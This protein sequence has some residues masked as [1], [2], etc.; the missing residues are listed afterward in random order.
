MN[1]RNLQDR[2]HLG[3]GLAA[4]HIGRPTDAFRP[5]GALHPLATRNRYLRLPATF[6]PS[7]GKFTRT[8]E[9]GNVLWFGVFDASY[10]RTGDY[11]VTE[12]ATFFVAS[13]APLLPV[14][15]VRTNRTISIAQ[16]KM[17]TNIASNPYGGYTPSSS[18]VLMDEWPASVI[19][20][21]RTSH[22]TTDLP[23]DQGAPYWNVLIPSIA[24]VG[25]S[26]GDMIND[27]LGRTAVVSASE[28]TN[29]GWRISARMAT[30]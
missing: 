12:D 26:P 13:Q 9:H 16:P 11:L 30:T 8:N 20:G 10:T 24:G 18:V 15:C 5:T 29:L 14:L 28:L 19:S 1:G 4:R 27:D 25:L 3:L 23:T 17:Q 7:Y 2:L 21:G 22:S 6:T